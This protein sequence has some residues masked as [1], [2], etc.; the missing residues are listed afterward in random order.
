MIGLGFGEHP[1]PVNSVSHNVAQQKL[2]T[3]HKEQIKK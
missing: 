3:P 2:E 1:S